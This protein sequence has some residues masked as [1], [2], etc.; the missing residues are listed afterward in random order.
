MRKIFALVVLALIF[1]PVATMSSAEAGWRGEKAKYAK[2]HSKKRRYSKRRKQVRGYRSRRGGYSYSANDVANTYGNSRT[3]Y[4]SVNSYRDPFSDRQTIAGP[5]D[6]G[7][8]FD[9]AVA[10]RGGDSPYMQ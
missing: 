3:R 1:T 6:H 5:F 2:V 10:P 8:F 9:S 4:G 7:W